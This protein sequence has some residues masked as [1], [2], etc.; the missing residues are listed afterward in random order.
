[1]RSTQVLLNTIEAIHAAGLDKDV[2]PDALGALA[3]AVGVPAATLETYD[4]AGKRHRRWHGHG[5]DPALRAEYLTLYNGRGSE[6]WSRPRFPSP[7]P[8]FPEGH[9]FDASGRAREP[10]YTSYLG[11][12]N[13]H[14]FAVGVV[15]DERRQTVI[16]VRQDEAAGALEQAAVERFSLLFG[17]VRQAL[18]VGERLAAANL[19]AAGLT[20]ALDAM[21]RAAGVLAADGGVLH[22]NAALLRLA[23]VRDGLSVGRA[24]LGFAAPACR[25]RFEL[26][27][28][29]ALA[30]GRGETGPAPEPFVT[31]RLSGAP[32]WLVVL[33]PILEPERET[34]GGDPAVLVL[35]HD[36]LADGGGTTDAA[37]LKA[38]FGLTDVEA[39]MAEALVQ[40]QSPSTWARRR[41]V[42]L[43]TAYTH[44]RRL[45]EKTGAGR[46]SDLIRRLNRA[47]IA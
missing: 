13:L 1:M 15:G 36:P 33:K 43:N 37:G 40:G 23:E 24:G 34:V 28:A 19:Q 30:L 16:T 39:A 7:R 42:S 45:K 32:S 11:A 9:V 46:L 47:D 41:A 18:V 12:L 20:A 25:R 44:L 14:L 35:I 26:A 21:R 31:P 3:D 2:W 4:L 5:I 17:H 38:L 29:R 6:D 27:M 8:R 10:F 22:A